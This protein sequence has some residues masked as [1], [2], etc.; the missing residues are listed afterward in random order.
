MQIEFQIAESKKM[1]NKTRP[2]SFQNQHCHQYNLKI[3]NVSSCSFSCWV[4]FRL[5]FTLH[6][7]NFFQ[8]PLLLCQL[9]NQTQ[10]K[11]QIKSNRSP[12]PI[13]SSRSCECV[14]STIQDTTM[15]IL[16][17]LH[18]FPPR[19]SFAPANQKILYVQNS[20]LPVLVAKCGQQRSSTKIKKDKNLH[21]FPLDTL[22]QLE[23]RRHYRS[24]HHHYLLPINMV[25][26][27]ANKN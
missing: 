4:S 6:T 14:N 15:S 27:G 8:V 23:N 9:S 19:P 20:S 18:V 5:C 2:Q 17:A 22:L 12:K 16:F 10:I 13:E 7:T 26:E 3:I 24:H 1:A 25:I 21:V 11:T